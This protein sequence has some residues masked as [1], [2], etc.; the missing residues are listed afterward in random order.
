MN[1]LSVP[2]CEKYSWNI[3]EAVAYFGIGEKKLRELID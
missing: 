2:I 3:N 1:K